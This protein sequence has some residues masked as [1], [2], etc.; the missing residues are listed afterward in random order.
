MLQQQLRLP[1]SPET[2]ACIEREGLRRARWRVALVLFV[3]LA[4]SAGASVG[5]PSDA[6]FEVVPS[7]PTTATPVTARLTYSSPHAVEVEEIQ[8]VGFGDRRVVLRP[9][10]CVITCPPQVFVLDVDLGLLAPG[11]RFV[12]AVFEGEQIAS[13][14][15]YVEV[16]DDL[17]PKVHATPEA[18]DTEDFVNLHLALLVEDCV[19]PLPYL[20]SIHRE[21]SGSATE[22]IVTLRRSIGGPPC[23][24]GPSR[25]ASIVVPLGG[26]PAGTVQVEVLLRT[27]ALPQSALGGS[28]SEVPERVS[29]SFMEPL[30]TTAF[31][32]AQGD[33][34]ALLGGRFEV[35][36]TFWDDAAQTE[37]PALVVPLLRAGGESADSALLGFYQTSN[38]EL[39]VKVLDGCAV[40]DHY[41]V[42]AAAAT[43]LG[44]RVRVRDRVTD[45]RFYAEQV[46]GLP[47]PPTT[48]T[49]ALP[50]CDPMDDVP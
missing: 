35:S 45:T 10:P 2:P 11:L 33:G 1:T 15:F 40:N 16:E 19:S 38:W 47:Q 31:Q 27:T 37:R 17:S 42:F 12:E 25:L 14:Q 21:F 13:I 44:W 23:D 6:S 34:V 50:V 22:V 41:W 49:Q 20:D 46:L 48:D 18:P 36:A 8:T 5:Q 9:L 26:L 43:D 39:L 30:A 24:P 3:A 28:G 7:G 32:V 4:L 29:G